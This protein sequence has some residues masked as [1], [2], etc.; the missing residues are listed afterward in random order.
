MKNRPKQSVV[1]ILK[2]KC[3]SLVVNAK[4]MLMRDVF[5]ALLRDGEFASQFHLRP[6]ATMLELYP[7]SNIGS[8]T[9]DPYRVWLGNLQPGLRPE[10][11]A[12]LASHRTTSRRIIDDLFMYP[13][14]C[15]LAGGLHNLR[16]EASADFVY[17]LLCLPITFGFWELIRFHP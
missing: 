16:P 12:D 13:C 3:R 5:A 2:N 4:S 11:S 6:L 14:S 7:K 8:N 17:R 1:G 9:I 15:V 10:A